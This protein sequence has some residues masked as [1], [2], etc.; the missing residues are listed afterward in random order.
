[1]Q[2]RSSRYP[3]HTLDCKEKVEE[4]FIVFRLQRVMLT[5]QD[6]FQ[7]I[8]KGEENKEPMNAENLVTQNR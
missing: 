6:N 4:F 2:C 5:I 3:L 1:M 8:P 7:L